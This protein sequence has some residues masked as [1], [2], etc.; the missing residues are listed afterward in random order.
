MVVANSD[1]FKVIQDITSR[2]GGV[3]IETPAQNAA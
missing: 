1:D 2:D 3:V